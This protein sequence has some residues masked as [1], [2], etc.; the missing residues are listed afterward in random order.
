MSSSRRYKD[1]IRHSKYK[2][3]IK[4]ILPFPYKYSQNWQKWIKFPLPKK[5]SMI[6]CDKTILFKRHNKKILEIPYDDVKKY[7]FFKDYWYINWKYSEG[8]VFYA[9]KKS[10]LNYFNMY[11]NCIIYLKPRDWY[12]NPYDSILSM[13]KMFEKYHTTHSS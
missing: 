7:G 11:N 3:K 8:T 6:F 1:D 12:S 2:I 10:F 9:S 5:L 13:N 4:R